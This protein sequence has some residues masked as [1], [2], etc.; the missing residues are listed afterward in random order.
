MVHENAPWVTKFSAYIDTLFFA[1]RHFA[2][3]LPLRVLAELMKM[4]GVFVEDCDDAAYRPTSAGKLAGSMPPK[5]GSAPVPNLTPF[6]PPLLLEYGGRHRRSQ[7]RRHLA[8]FRNT[9]TSGGEKF[10]DRVSGLDLKLVNRLLTT[11][12]IFSPRNCI[13]PLRFNL[14][15]TTQTDPI[16]A[17]GNSRQRAVDFTE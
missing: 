1:L 17:V 9:R 16:G 14:F 2:S 13:Q 8:A 4:R 11:E 7:T 15:F 5:N 3:G 6:W 12:T 10:V